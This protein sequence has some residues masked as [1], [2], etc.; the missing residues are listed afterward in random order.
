MSCNMSE[1]RIITL[2]MDVY[3]RKDISKVVCEVMTHPGYPCTDSTKGGCGTGADDFARSNDRRHE[4]EVL[5]SPT[6]Q[7]FLK[8]EEIMMTHTCIDY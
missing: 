7:A 5:T 8:N 2:L 4:L 6:M 1:D 3:K